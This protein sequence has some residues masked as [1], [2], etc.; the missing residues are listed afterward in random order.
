MLTDLMA[1]LHLENLDPMNLG[2]ALR[3]IVRDS[4]VRT[5]DQ[6]WAQLK[7]GRLAAVAGFRLTSRQIL[8]GSSHMVT[9]LDTGH[10]LIV[11]RAWNFEG[12]A[13][14]AVYDPNDEYR[15]G[16]PSRKYLVA[17]PGGELTYYH[18]GNADRE[19]VRFIPFRSNGVFELLS[20]MVQAGKEGVRNVVDRFVP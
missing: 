14:Y 2:E 7:Q 3:A 19:M 16:A 9:S 6:I 4:N 13:I 8:P 12:A 20:T 18:T 15:V 5:E 10:V 17:G 11:Y 1:K